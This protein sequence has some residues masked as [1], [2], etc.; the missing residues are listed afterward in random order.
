MVKPKSAKK[1]PSEL[2]NQIIHSKEHLNEDFLQANELLTN[3]AFNEDEENYNQQVA[4]E[5]DD[6]LLEKLKALDG[7]KL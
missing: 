2:E 3:E 6:F 4:E 5:K 1:I 7:R